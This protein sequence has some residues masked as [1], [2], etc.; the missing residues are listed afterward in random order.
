[1]NYTI[2][3]KGADR[4]VEILSPF[5][6]KIEIAGSIRR[7]KQKDIKDVEVVCIPKQVD[8][9]GTLMEPTKLYRHPGFA[10]ALDGW[11]K[12][13]GDASTGKYCQRILPGAWTLDV[14]IAT[15]TNWGWMLMLRTGSSEF[16]RFVM[17]EKLKQNGVHSIDGNL[18]RG[19]EVLETPTE[20]FVF[21][22]A[23]M[24][25]IPP[26]MRDFVT[27]NNHLI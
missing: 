7:Q 15:P 14:F 11:Q 22:L 2:A 17:L 24:K 27:K 4:I 19:G 1:M 26:R 21:E 8:G 16:N 20:D 3:K 5:C 10:Y 12:V 6:E 9:P 18:V 13:K 25:P 23:G